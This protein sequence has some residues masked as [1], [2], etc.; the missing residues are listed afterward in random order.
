M[1]VK[2]LAVLLAILSCLL[3]LQ[4]MSLLM[5]HHYTTLYRQRHLILSQLADSGGRKCPKRSRKT[6]RFWVRPGR[7]AAWWD[8][9]MNGT[10]LEEEWKENFRLSR[11]S[12]IKLTD[13]LRPYI[14]HQV[15]HM[16]SPL[17]VETQVA[18]TLYYLS[19]EGRL[20]KVANAFGISRSSCS[21]IV[22]RVSK[23]IT[24]HLGPLYI[25]LPM[26]EEEIKETVSKFYSAFEI[27]QCLGAIDGTH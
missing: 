6:R 27:P 13:M 17:P 9:F 15:T 8:N 22:R 23:V 25:K 26:T 18:I 3:M 11:A 21:I 10:V 12:F 20:R 16:R 24:N 1:E 2:R 4:E 5:I 7:T 19:D 14:E